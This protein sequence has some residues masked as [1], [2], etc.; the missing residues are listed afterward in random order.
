[1]IC[2]FLPEHHAH[3]LCLAKILQVNFFQ[4]GVFRTQLQQLQA[5]A[6]HDADDLGTDIVRATQEPAVVARLN[7]NGLEDIVT[8]L[9]GRER[10]VRLMDEL[11]GELGDDPQKWLPRLLEKAR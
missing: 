2:Q 3:D 9:S 6:R 7:L 1:M 10:T 4:S 11:R 8:I 5:F